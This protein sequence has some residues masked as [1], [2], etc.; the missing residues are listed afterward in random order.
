MVG[1]TRRRA[2]DDHDVP[3]LVR[4][5][6][7]A[8]QPRVPAWLLVSCLAACSLIV[9]VP[10]SGVKSVTF[11]VVSLASRADLSGGR[12]KFRHQLLVLIVS[13]ASCGVIH[14]E[15]FRGEFA[16][17]DELLTEFIGRHCLILLL[18]DSE[19][20]EAE[21]VFVIRAGFE[22][23]IAKHIRGVRE[24]SFEQHFPAQLVNI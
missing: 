8:A 2:G 17:L 10:H 11:S 6:E 20:N 15:H 16:A 14:I 21:T 9:L 18:V 7:H 13:Q 19:F 3:L 22:K 23:R 24:Q 4:L 5:A 12:L 1:S